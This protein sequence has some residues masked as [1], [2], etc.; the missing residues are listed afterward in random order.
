[1]ANPA[2]E[3]GVI[4]RAIKRGQV[5][6]YKEQNQFT[7]SKRFRANLSEEIGRYQSLEEALGHVSKT[8]SLKKLER[9]KVHCTYCMDDTSVEV[10]TF[11][12]CKVYI[13]Q[14]FL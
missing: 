1:M 8:D 4:C 12:G 5:T 6:I 7:V 9:S 11:C 2:N 14:R 13:L 3:D 10:C